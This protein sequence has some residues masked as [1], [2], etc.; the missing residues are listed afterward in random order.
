[1]DCKP[2]DHKYSLSKC[3]TTKTANFWCLKRNYVNVKLYV[4]YAISCLTL[5]WR[6]VQHFY[7]RV[8]LRNELNIRFFRLFRL[9]NI[10]E[11]HLLLN[12]FYFWILGRDERVGVFLKPTQNQPIFS[13]KTVAFFRR[14]LNLPE[15]SLKV[16]SFVR[17]SVTVI[18]F[19]FFNDR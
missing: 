3:P 5:F 15:I 11:C 2:Y 12:L 9:P 14:I 6:F 17:K 7:L 19:S 13:Y 18:L 8:I 16:A 1:M 10:E 4:V